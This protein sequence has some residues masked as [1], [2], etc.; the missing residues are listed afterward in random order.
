MQWENE[1]KGCKGTDIGYCEELGLHRDRKNGSARKVFEYR[2][3]D[4]I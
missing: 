3:K 1:Y 4:G 2:R